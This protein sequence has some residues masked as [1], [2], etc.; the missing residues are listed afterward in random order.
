[1]RF[2][3]VW[4]FLFITH[5]S[6]AQAEE[7]FGLSMVGNP[8]YTEQSTHYDMPTRTRQRAAR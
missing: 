7:I 3:I 6:I 4:I 8:K 5:A 1:M 2:F